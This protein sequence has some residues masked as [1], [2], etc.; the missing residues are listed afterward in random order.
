MNLS[1]IQE[2]QS[3][4][5]DQV[6]IIFSNDGD[7]Q[8]AVVF[9][10][11]LKAD[12]KSISFWFYQFFSLFQV[13]YFTINFKTKERFFFNQQSMYQNHVKLVVVVV[14]LPFKEIQKQFLTPLTNIILDFILH[15]LSTSNIHSLSKSNETYDKT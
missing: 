15:L 6:P 1:V 13:L 14:H 10:N 7:S 12:L 2:L 3:N 9:L 4:E 8:I 5:K 11:I